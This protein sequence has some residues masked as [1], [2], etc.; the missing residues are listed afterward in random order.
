MLFFTELQNWNKLFENLLINQ[1][2]L[3]KNPILHKLF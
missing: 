1:S 3:L 2:F